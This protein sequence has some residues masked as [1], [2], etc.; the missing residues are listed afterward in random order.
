MTAMNNPNPTTDLTLNFQ[1]VKSAGKGKEE[2]R[3]KQEEIDS[4]TDDQLELLYHRLC[5]EVGLRR[6]KVIVRDKYNLNGYRG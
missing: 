5:N 1:V 2:L 3:M 6:M 4:L